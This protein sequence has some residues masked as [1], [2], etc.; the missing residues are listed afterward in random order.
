MEYMRCL[1]C[2]PRCV[3][4]PPLHVYIPP[5]T[6]K[7]AKHLPHT[8]AYQKKQSY[9]ESLIQALVSGISIDGTRVRIWSSEGHGRLGR[10]YALTH[11]FH[12]LKVSKTDLEAHNY[13]LLLSRGIPC[14][15]VVESRDV[16]IDD[17]V[18]S[19]TIMNR[20]EFTLSALIRASG[21]T[22]QYPRGLAEALIDLL[23]MLKRE[24]IAYVDLSPDN[25][26][27]SKGKGNVF[28]VH[29]IDPQFVVPLD[30]FTRVYNRH[31]DCTYLALKLFVLGQLH[32]PC[33]QYAKSLCRSL[34]GY[35]PSKLAVVD[36]LQTTAVQAL[37]YVETIRSNT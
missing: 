16:R 1:W 36:F 28:A 29:V 24:N 33:T 21:Y 6:V 14:A 32:P 17:L 15:H 4:V 11:P 34:L 12:V 23:Y 3:S 9:T 30:A 35:V 8:M 31:Y 13:S 7:T 10:V 19:V 18:Y 5:D 2:P 20:L 37:K 22:R 26:M 25:I 27:F